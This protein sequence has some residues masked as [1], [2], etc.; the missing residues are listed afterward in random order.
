[1]EVEWKAKMDG[2]RV[3]VLGRPIPRYSVLKDVLV[4]KQSAFRSTGK[5]GE[6][7]RSRQ[8]KGRGPLLSKPIGDQSWV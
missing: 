7:G 6:G 3:R 8:Q 5:G 1:M 4:E 2:Y